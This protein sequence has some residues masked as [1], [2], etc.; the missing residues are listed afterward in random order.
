M[1]RKKYF[2]GQNTQGKESNPAESILSRLEKEGLSTEFKKWFIQPNNEQAVW[3][4]AERIKEKRRE[5]KEEIN[6]SQ[7]RKFFGSFNEIFRKSKKGWNKD[8]EAELQLKIAELYYAKG[9]GLISDNFLKV[10]EGMA[11][12]IKNKEDMEVFMD[13]MKALIAY[14]KYF[15]TTKKE[16]R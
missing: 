3:G 11:Q 6:I 10:V 2:S 4:L 7:L 15:E 16:R 12:K 9:R 14:V 5:K 8:L 1:D 13:C